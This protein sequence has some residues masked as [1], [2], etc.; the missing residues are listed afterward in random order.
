MSPD[1]PVP[2]APSRLDRSKIGTKVTNL[3]YDVEAGQLRFFSRTVGET[4][5]VYFDEAAARAAGYRS[6]IAP[7]TFG[8]SCLRG[9]A[10]QMPFMTAMGLGEDHLAICLHGEQSFRYEGVICAGDRISIE[11]EIVDVYDKRGGEMEFLL[12]RTLLSN[13]LGERVAEMTG[14][15]IF[16]RRNAAP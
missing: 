8:F 9:S 16:D 13:Q 3:F 6:I 14:T 7:P 5:P 10:D 4:D 1:D 15:L 2:A 11:E 12:T